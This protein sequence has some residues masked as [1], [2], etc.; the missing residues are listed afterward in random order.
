MPIFVWRYRALCGFDT[1]ESDIDD[2]LDG[3]SA[4]KLDQMRQQRATSNLQ[5]DPKCPTTWDNAPDDPFQTKCTQTDVRHTQNQK[6]LTK[7]LLRHDRSKVPYNAWDVAHGDQ[8]LQEH[9][10]RRTMPKDLR[11]S[12]HTPK[13]KTQGCP[14][15]PETG[16]ATQTSPRL[17]RRRRQPKQC[18][19]E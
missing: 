5:I 11:R 1:D 4:E 17:S 3:L 14:S 16:K 19:N 2:Y 15:S 6:T 8:W 9:P 18:I 12:N 13:D 10:E 7:R